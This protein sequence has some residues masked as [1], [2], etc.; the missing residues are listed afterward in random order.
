MIQEGA[1]LNIYSICEYNKIKMEC[2][3]WEKLGEDRANWDTFFFFF[4]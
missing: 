3:W 2:F 1:E 4:N